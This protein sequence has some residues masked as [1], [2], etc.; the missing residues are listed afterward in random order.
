MRFRIVR[1][2]AKRNGSKRTIFVNGG[3]GLLQMVSEP[4]TGRC[5]SENAGPS[6]GVDCGIPIG[7]RG[8]QT[9][10]KG[11]KTSP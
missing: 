10:Y 9:I 11:V 3:F 6:R 5:A 7:W 4:D 8:Q 1:L 2:T